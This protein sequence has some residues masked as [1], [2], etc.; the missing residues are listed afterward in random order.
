MVGE[1]PSTHRCMV[2]IAAPPPPP[3][4]CLPGRVHAWV[5]CGWALTIG[6]PI[7]QALPAQRHNAVL[8]LISPARGCVLASLHWQGSLQEVS[9]VRVGLLFPPLTTSNPIPPPLHALIHAHMSVCMHMYRHMYAYT[10]LC[11]RTYV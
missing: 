8:A 6:W 2:C 3:F 10:Y 1:E 11:S 4:D 7:P 5:G 9:G